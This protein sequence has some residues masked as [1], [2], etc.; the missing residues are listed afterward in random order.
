MPSGHKSAKLTHSSNEITQANVHKLRRP[1]D[2]QIIVQRHKDTARKARVPTNALKHTMNGR[3]KAE[4]PKG[5]ALCAA[6]A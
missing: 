2:L 5:A 6:A 3:G 4:R 1:S